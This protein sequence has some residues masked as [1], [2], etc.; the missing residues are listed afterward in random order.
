MFCQ[1]IL[2][3]LLKNAGAQCCFRLLY[4]H[5]SPGLHPAGAWSRKV[6]KASSIGESGCFCCRVCV[7][8]TGRLSQHLRSL[9]AVS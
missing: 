3:G 4:S 8:F 1:S 7:W 9:D 2:I 5:Q 6:A